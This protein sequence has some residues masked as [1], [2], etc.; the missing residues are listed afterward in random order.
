MKFILFG[1]GDIGLRALS[2]IGSAHVEYFADNYKAGMLVAG[3]KVIS[4]EKMI[5]LSK[6]YAIVV[7]TNEYISEFESQLI[8]AGV[9]QYIVF[10]RRYQPEMNKVLPKYNYLYNTQYMNYTDILLN[11]KIYKYK[12]IVI[13][14]TN[15]YINNLIFEIAVLSELNNVKAI[16]SDFETDQYYGIKV[17]GTSKISEEYDCVI[18]NLPRE[19]SDIRE[20]LDYS[21]YAVVDIYDVDQ[22]IAYNRYQELEKYKNI[23]QGK[24][25]FIIG[26]GPS[27]TIDDLNTLHKYGEICFGMNK[28]YKIFNET[29]WRPQYICVTDTRV[30]RAC[31]SYLDVIS[32][33]SEIIMA[34]RYTHTYEKWNGLSSINYVHLKSEGYMPNYPGFSDDITKGVFWGNTVVYDIALQFAAYMGASE[35]YLLGID[36]NNVGNVTD[37][38]N[39]FIEDYFEKD[40]EGIYKNVVANFDA[41]TVAYEKAEKYSR[42]H[43]FRIF[44]ATR[45]GKL[46]VF[47]RVSFDDLFN[48]EM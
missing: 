6:R 17:I 13:A 26:N 32:K 41:M 23:Y 21:K 37:P 36:H 30:M 18:V 35:I 12:K 11:Y 22:Y 42:E 2:V 44:N 4:F 8:A 33:Q 19:K 40:E 14:G 9:K 7:T 34:D 46:E 28:V 5:E 48:D 15:E 43:G 24:R 38:R 31:E 47:E 29:P 20:K 10:V 1:A 39:H 25:V 27:V 45:G 3:K 16:A